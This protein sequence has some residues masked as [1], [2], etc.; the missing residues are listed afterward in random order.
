MGKMAE[1]GR[2]VSMTLLQSDALALFG[3]EEEDVIVV[4]SWIEYSVNVSP[5][6][7]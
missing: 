3:G 6:Y 4:G 5:S 1:G 2:V 7:S